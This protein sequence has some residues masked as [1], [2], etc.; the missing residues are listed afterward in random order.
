[1]G[2]AIVAV[3][4]IAA[5]VYAYQQEKEPIE[6]RGSATEEFVTTEEPKPPP[7][8]RLNP[9]PWPTYGYDAAR[10]HISPYDH[11]PPFRRLWKID[12]HDSLEFPPSVGYGRVYLAQQKGLF[13]AL[14][15][16]TGKVDWRK[17][18]GR[19][20]ASSPTI[21]KGVVYQSYMHPVECPQDQA[22]RRRL[23]RRLGRRHRPG[24]VALQVGA[25]RVVAAAEERPTLRRHL[26]PQRLR[27]ERQD[28]QADLELPGRRPGQHVGRL[29]ARGASSSRRTA[30][31]STR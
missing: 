13:F 18:L 25:D 20:A 31:R 4:A 23:P 9:R 7:P 30:A 2:A 14:D 19:C 17:S 10:Q 3:L 16:K 26:G 15:A 21:G 27:L 29:L 24:A 22:G 12:A 11:R 28:R 8:R 1:M 6:K 5:G